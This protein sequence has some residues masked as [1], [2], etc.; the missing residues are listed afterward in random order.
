LDS[1]DGIA[2]HVQSML[3]DPRA[4][5]A[6]TRFTNEWLA[7]DG[8]E[9]SD[10]DPELYPG[11]DF[12]VR[13]AALEETRRFAV[14]RFRMD[15]GQLDQLFLANRT[16][17]DE[18]LASIYGAPVNGS[19]FVEATLDPSQRFGLLTQISF[20][21]SHSNFAQSSPIHRG[22]TVRERLLCQEL[23]PPPSNVEIEEPEV[24]P[25][26]PTRERF[27]Q[28]REDPAC[29]SCHILIDP[30]GFGFE[31]Y[32]AVGRYRRMDGG[33]PVDTSGEIT[34][35]TDADGLFEGMGELAERLSQS[36][37]VRQ[38]VTH[39]WLRFA[40]G[41]EVSAEAVERIHA[42]IA[43]EDYRMADAIA[44]VLSSPE[45][46]LLRIDGE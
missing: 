8:V 4:D 17:V 23:P 39:Q 42:P 35:T 25:N 33:S 31:A 9:A 18:A 19:G 2:R 12:S 46:T 32:D 21:A 15:G 36:E 1:A 13:S 30:I 11:F 7:I 24:D 14:H 44:A 37:H 28:H 29:A 5:W 20:L 16:F 43:G 22:V 6:I 10:K 27:A 40:L 3:E 34:S 26:V 41:H 38:C 45:F